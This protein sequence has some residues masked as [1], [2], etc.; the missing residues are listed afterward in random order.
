MDA[1]TGPGE[2]LVLADFK[3]ILIKFPWRISGDTRES[4]SACKLREGDERQRKGCQHHRY[5]HGS[6]PEDVTCAI[7]L[8]H[9][10]SKGTAIS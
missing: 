8:S 7:S 1:S 3:D 6:V 9:Y 10:A 4:M 2:L 5:S